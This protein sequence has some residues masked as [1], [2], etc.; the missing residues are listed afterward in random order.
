MDQFKAIA[1]F[2]QAASLGSFGRAAKKLGVTQQQVSKSIRQLEEHLGARLFN[3]TTRQISLTEA[4]FAFYAEASEGMEKLTLA[5]SNI[6]SGN[7]VASGTVRM[8]LPKALAARIV[9]P[10]L[11]KFRRLYPDITVETIIDD[12]STDL[13]E[14]RIDIGLRAGALQDGRLV[15]LKLIPIQHI[16]CAAPSFLAEHGIP[17]DINDLA[18]FDCTAFRHIKT[19]KILPWEFM[20][21]EH[22]TCRDQPYVFATNDV[23]AECEAVVNGIGIGQL[24][25]FTAVPLILESRLVPLFPETITERFA[26]YLYFLSREH[27][28]KR[29]RLLIDFLAGHIRGNERFFISPAAHAEL[30]KPLR[31]HRR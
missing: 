20:L 16:V 14:Q 24:A 29:V 21:D 28:P 12:E 22:L 26:L 25:S 6:R 2:I 8:T 17:N 7:E 18:N 27:Q 15:A 19:G 30:L 3:R 31:T 9:I 10:L 5:F 4:G 23:E 13:I 1:T 11:A